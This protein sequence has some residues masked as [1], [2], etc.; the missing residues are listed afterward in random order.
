[1]AAGSPEWSGASDCARESVGASPG[2]RT[3]TRQPGGARAAT[4]ARSSE[5]LPTPEGPITASSRRALIFRHSAAASASRPKKRSASASVKAARPGVRVLLL[6]R[7]GR[8]LGDRLRR[9]GSHGHRTH[10]GDQPV[11]ALADGLDVAGVLGVIAEG[12]AKF[13]DPAGDGAV[14]H[15]LGLPHR[16]E[17]GVLADHLA[18]VRHQAEQD[19]DGLRLELDRHL[20]PGEPIESGLDQPL[21]DEERPAFLGDGLNL[22]G[23]SGVIVAL[24]D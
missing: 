3:T 20:T 4:P 1:M 15:E 6:V 17:Q 14:G 24:A 5:L 10:L 9:V 2:V 21:P 11:A 16:V 13:A 12:V 7:R 19:V 8:R 23:H 18:G 22:G